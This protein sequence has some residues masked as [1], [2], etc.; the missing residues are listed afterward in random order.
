MF[1][2]NRK[3]KLYIKEINGDLVEYGEKWTKYQVELILND[4]NWNLDIDKM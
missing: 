2:D 3:G 1:F 4:K